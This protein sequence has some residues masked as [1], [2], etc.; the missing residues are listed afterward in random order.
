MEN[1]SPESKSEYTKYK[2]FLTSTIRKSERLYYAQQFELKM[3][4]MRT[5]WSLINAIVQTTRGIKAHNHIIINCDGELIKDSNINSM[6][7]SLVSV[8]SWEVIFLV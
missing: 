8:L 1:N 6:F 4:N 3:N 2:T 7:S 5:T